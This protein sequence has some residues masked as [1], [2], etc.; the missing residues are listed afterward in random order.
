MHDKSHGSQ[1]DLSRH[2]GPCAAL[3]LWVHW[4]TLAS[5]VNVTTHTCNF[6]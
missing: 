2:S 4:D 3:G 5:K 6:I 1:G